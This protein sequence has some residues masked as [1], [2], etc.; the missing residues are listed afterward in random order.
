MIP[1]FAHNSFLRCRLGSEVLSFVA[2]LE[3]KPND[4]L[5]Q[6]STV[7]QVY[8]RKTI[9]FPALNW[10]YGWMGGGQGLKRLDR[11]WEQNRKRLESRL[12]DNSQ[13]WKGV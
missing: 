10:R 11:N 12:R 3:L 5:V 6:L 1:F 2:D 13:I 9:S 7:P 4:P 8:E